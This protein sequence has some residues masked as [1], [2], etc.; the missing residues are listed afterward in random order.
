MSEVFSFCRCKTKEE[1]IS[2]L[3]HLAWCCCQISNNEPYNETPDKEQIDFLIE[4]TSEV[5]S[6]IKENGKDKFTEETS[7]DLWCKSKI[8]QGWVYGKEKDFNKK[9]HPDLVPFEDL[10]KDEKNKDIVD[11]FM[12]KAA[13]DLY[14]EWFK[15]LN[16][17]LTLIHKDK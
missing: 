4:N 9:T 14:D 5:L 11:N 13:S 6:F 16:P 8:N 2:R 15:I 1:F 17:D 10:S 12:I 3:R 7:H